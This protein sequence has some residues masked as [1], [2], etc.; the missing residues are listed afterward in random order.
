VSAINPSDLGYD[1]LPPDPGLINPDLALDAALA[2]TVTVD[3]DAPIPF[4]RSWRFDFTAGQFI[5]D[6][7]APQ[8]TYEMDTLI[9]WVEKTCRTALF[10]HP[11][12]SDQYGVEITDLIGMQVDDELLSGYQNAITQALLVHDRIV[13]VQ[14]FS[15]NQDPFDEGLY[16]SF[17][18]VLDTAPPFEAQPVEFT[19]VPVT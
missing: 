1:L 2:P 7:T 9:V 14:D 8:E 6:G 15:F 18:V 19:N 11:I 16:A 10:A 3:P 12:Y 5:Y 4:G 17:T 13:S